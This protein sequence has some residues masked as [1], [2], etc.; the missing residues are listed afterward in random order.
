MISQAEYSNALTALKKAK[1]ILI[2]AHRKLDP[3]STGSILAL[4][5]A[6][7]AMG[8]SAQA[9]CQ[10]QPPKILEFLPDISSI[11]TKSV[12]PKDLIISLNNPKVAL[13]EVTYATNEAGKVNIIVSSDGQYAPEDIT[14]LPAGN[15][16]DT[17]VIVDSGD[18]AALGNVY[19]DNKEL[20][21]KATVINID[22][23][24]S[25]GLFGD[26][27]LVDPKASS[28]AELVY[29]VVKQLD[30]SLI[31]P[32]IATYLLL[33]IIGDTGSFQHSNTTPGAL[34]AA[35]DLV[36]KG[37][38]QQEIIKHL[39]KTKKFATL[40]LWGKTLSDI[41][42]DEAHHILWSKVSY[43]DLSQL[44]TEVEDAKLIVDELLSSAPA[45]DFYILFLEKAPGV[46]SVSIRS[47]TPGVSGL[48]IAQHFG[49]GGHK[50]ACGFTIEN[51]T[52][53][54][55]IPQVLE[56]VR[57]YQLQRTG[58]STVSQAEQV[59]TAKRTEEDIAADLKK[60]IIL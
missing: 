22:H 37:A 27:N 56:R 24:S 5:C 34:R 53:E 39:Y 49:G 31:E 35:S 17:I 2:T 50:Q 6:L 23:H 10:E 47:R 55:L 8:K 57:A 44:H 42:V 58:L 9:I 21:E 29:N 46:I 59:H 26:I 33:G 60:D 16:F 18:N 25:N 45:M 14:I 30:E 4:L 40:K 48:E 36:N 41:Q 54:S 12:A 20:F 52:L 13:R 43:E 28:A 38:R 3:D 15:H 32:D 19:E 51:S 1:N 7:K 11:Q